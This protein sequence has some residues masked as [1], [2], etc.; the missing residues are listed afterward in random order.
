VSLAVSLPV[1]GMPLD[2]TVDLVRTA[3]GWGYDAVWASE[4]AGP[5]FATLLG[6]VAA[7]AGGD[8]D[9]GIAVAPVQTRTPWLLAATAA[10]LHHL[11][12]GRFTLGVGTSSEVI[13][14]QWSGLEFDRPLDHLREVIGLLRTIFAGER[15]AYDGEFVRSHGY[16]LFAPAEVPIVVGALNPRSLRQAGELGDGVCLNQL[17]AEHLPKALAEVR[18]GAEAVGRDA[19]GLPVVARLFCQVTD[20]VEATREAVRRTFA[21]YIATSVYNR[22]YRWLGFEEEAAAVQAALAAGDR[23]GAVA[24]ISDAVLDA[25][26]AIG[27]EDAVAARVQAYVDAGVTVPVISCLAPGREATERTLRAIGER[28]SVPRD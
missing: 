22:F 27:D 8:L 2:Q 15:T 4:V 24:A 7:G 28:V 14:E 23:A 16:R 20:D 26:T 1:P 9:L 11:S 3:R 12:G 18:A 6:A 17:G 5:D 13:V 25:V 10:S 21:P 19:T